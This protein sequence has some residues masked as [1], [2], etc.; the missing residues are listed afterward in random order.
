MAYF[1][2]AYPHQADATSWTSPM[3]WVLAGSATTGV[4]AQAL[5]L[6]VPLW[7]SGFRFRPRWGVRGVGLR[8]ASTVALW[9]FAATGVAA[10]GFIITSRVL[11]YAG[12]AGSL[13]GLEAVSYTHLRA[14]ETR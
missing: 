14:H 5:V 13:A 9:T 4:A 6:V 2:V 8:T 12:Q 1:L 3:I 7:R 10:A 11:T